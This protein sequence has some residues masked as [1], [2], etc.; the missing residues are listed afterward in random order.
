MVLDSLGG[1]SSEKRQT[2][3]KEGFLHR[4]LIRDYSEYGI[5]LIVQ[6]GSQNNIFKYFGTM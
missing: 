2:A 4:L 3:V 5:I 1:L 6:L